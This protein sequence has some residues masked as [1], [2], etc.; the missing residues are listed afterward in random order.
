MNQRSRLSNRV[1]RVAQGVVR[2]DFVVAVRT[3]QQQVLH[4]RLDQQVLKQI[5]R[6]SIEP[7]QIVEEERQRMLL[8]GEHPQEP[9]EHQLETPLR[10]LRRQFG[11]RGLL[12][13]DESQIR[14]Q[15]YD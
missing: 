14:D 6:R 5:E 1:E 12:A 15:V 4:V 8:R 2:R 7:L 9:P 10:V 3:D 11:K 13:D